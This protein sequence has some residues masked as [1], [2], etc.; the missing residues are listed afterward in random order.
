[1]SA[2]DATLPTLARLCFRVPVE[3][4]SS[5]EAAYH[6]CLVPILKQHG[7]ME[8]SEPGRPVARVL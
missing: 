1:M 3:H 8:S 6:A 2:P 5:F 4:L 7:L